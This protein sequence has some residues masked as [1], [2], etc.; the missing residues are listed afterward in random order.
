MSE[1]YGHRERLREKYLNHGMTGFYH[2]Y[3]K[4]EFLLT[5]SI[6]QKDIKPIAKELLEKFYTI[7]GVLK[8]DVNELK[9]IKGVG[10]ITALYLNYIGDLNKELFKSHYKVEK[11]SINSKNDLIAYLKNEIGFDSRENF[12][13]LYLDS[14]NHLINERE[15]KSE[16]LFKGTIDRSAVY[17]REIAAKIVGVK[18][19]TN[20][21]K[22]QNENF[23]I[24]LD[25][26]NGYKKIIEESI[27]YK[28]KSVIISHNHPSGNYKPSR[29]DIE[30]T[31]TL[32][33][34]LGMLDIRL[35]DHL[36][37]TKEAYF[38]FLE[39]GLLE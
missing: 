10:E 2:E 4:L 38:S 18:E 19:K 28:A 1:K 12:F 24:V 16:I 15:L 30:L 25:K 37:V 31:Q 7:E 29:S 21:L 3:E 14:A 6:P 20:E 9:K 27:N 11:I 17:P 5:F 22:N 23:E 32:K 13:I 36:I 34:T 8:A 33:S 35:L 26:E 39:E